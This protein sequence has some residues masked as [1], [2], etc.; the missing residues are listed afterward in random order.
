MQAFKFLARGGGSLVAVA[1][2]DFG[3]RAFQAVSFC[4]LR[5]GKQHGG[6][7]FAVSRETGSCSF[8]CWL[9]AF[10]A[11]SRRA[12]RESR[13]AAFRFAREVRRPPVS[14]GRTGCRPRFARGLQGNDTSGWPGLPVSQAG[15][16]SE[17]RFP[18]PQMLHVKQPRRDVVRAAVAPWERV[19]SRAEHG[20]GPVW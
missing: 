2:V 6:E 20:K 12:S 19:R 4:G 5:R 8:S 9:P 7:R 1:A 16:R 15:S 10:D 17:G 14:R 3:F 11:R 13:G 18:G